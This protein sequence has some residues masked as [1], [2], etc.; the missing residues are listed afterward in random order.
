MIHLEI[1]YRNK[2]IEQICTNKSIAQTKYG[3]KMA[4]KIHACIDQIKAISSVEMLIRFRIGRC[5]ILIGDRKG[6]YAMDL[7]HP[8]R[9]V[10]TVGN[11]GNIQIANIIE[12]I[13]YH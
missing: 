11:D 2:S 13:D 12:I 7:D 9:L 4:I 1:T 10:F 3:T 5:H 6:Q 8:Y